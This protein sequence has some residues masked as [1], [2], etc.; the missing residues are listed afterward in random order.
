MLVTQMRQALSSSIFLS[1]VSVPQAT[2]GDPYLLNDSAI[3]LMQ[4][5]EYEKALE[6][7]QNAFSLFP[8]NEPI[9][10]SLTAAYVEVGKRQLTRNQSDAAA[11]NFE[12]AL[13]LSPDIQAY[14]I[15]RG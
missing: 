8:Y 11:E 9:R 12:N 4:R 13:K 6:Q 3:E 15:L 2:A 14:G 5:G 10:K 7:L 1:A